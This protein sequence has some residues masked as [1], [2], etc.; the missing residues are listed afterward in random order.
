MRKI[1]YPVLALIIANIIWGATS[2]I[3]KYSLEN[4][5]PFS[6]A[7]IRF[8]LASLILFP[9]VHTK[10]D[11]PDLKNR[12]LW[13]YAF[14]GITLN[15]IFFFL[16]LQRTPSINAPII[17][18]SGPILGLVGALIFLKEKVSKSAVVGTFVALLGIVVVIL[19]PLLKSGLNTEMV[20]NLLMV[21]A[22]LGAV[23]AC[24]AGR[25]FLTPSNAL[26]STF[27]ACLI[28][29]LSFAP[30]MFWEYL[31]NP[32]WW[33]SLDI[34]GWVGI[35]YG[36]IFA[37]CIAYAT[38]NWALAKL[39]AY[40]TSVFTYIDP[41]AAIIIAVPLL[42]EKIT[43]PFIIGSILVFLGILISERRIHY[44]PLHKLFNN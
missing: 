1:N 31:Q 34:R 15:I 29:T 17:G 3:L 9:F 33:G 25:K 5:P 8:L 14:F 19:Q 42:G 27:W 40:K 28:G 21:L 39:P 44:H 2:P 43:P 30:L 18:S 7:F 20:G 4:I 26:G 16:A 24:M 23:I 36:G 35:I 12:W 37:S 10:I 13:M 6:L 38:Y 11:Y 41:V 22:T 32:T